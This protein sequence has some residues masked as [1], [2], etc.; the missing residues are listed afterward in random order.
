MVMDPK[1]IVADEPISALDVSIRAQVLN[2][3]NK[4]KAEKN[5]T[6]LFIAHDLSVVRFIADRIAVI[7]LGEIVEIADS[8]TLFCYPIHPYTVSLL[9]SVPMPDPVVERT[10][11]HIDYDPSVLDQ[12]GAPRSMQ[13]IRPGHF[14]LAT[15]SE[16]EGYKKRIEELEARR[17]KKTGTL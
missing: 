12:S 14:I 6:Y 15:E 13:E 16:L 5:L 2:L 11:R 10:R 8:E 17:V 7:H 4:L 3:M 9:S 1:F